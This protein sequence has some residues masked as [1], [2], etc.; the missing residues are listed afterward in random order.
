MQP[1]QTSDKPSDIV[2]NKS[3]SL[4]ATD[5]IGRARSV[6]LIVLAF[7]FTTFTSLLCT[8]FQGLLPLLIQEKVQ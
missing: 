7:F 2:N 4:E 1:K 3:S 5:Y 6:V 8:G